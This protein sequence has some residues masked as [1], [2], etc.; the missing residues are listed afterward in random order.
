[1]KDDP[2]EDEV[3]ECPHEETTV[4]CDG[5]EHYMVC[6]ECGED[7]HYESCPE[8]GSFPCEEP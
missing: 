5:T 2:D 7:A 4:T 1:M 6:Q 3:Y 8:A